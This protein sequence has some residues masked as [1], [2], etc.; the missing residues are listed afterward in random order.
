MVVVGATEIKN[1]FGKYLSRV[2]KGEEVIIMKN[3]KEVA[4]LVSTKTAHE[5]V[6]KSLR[7]VFKDENS[8]KVDYENERDEYFKEKY[9]L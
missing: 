3:G 5:S 9:N 8:E 7:G 2:I 6:V 1:N 4:R